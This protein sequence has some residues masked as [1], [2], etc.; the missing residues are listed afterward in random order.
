MLINKLTNGGGDTEEGFR[1]S[2][3]TRM[4]VYGV[5]ALVGFA[6]IVS[7]IIATGG[8]LISGDPTSD[9]E[10]GFG[11]G[12]GSAFVAAGLVNFLKTR[13]ALN[14]PNRFR[15]AYTEYADERNRFVIMKTYQT[16]SAIF[17]CVMALAVV[18]AATFFKNA[19]VAN[20]LG[21]CLSAFSIIVFV[22]QRIVNR[23]Y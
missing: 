20:T 18:A 15:K 12:L 11:I 4:R 21:V 1:A 2:L 9:Y 17:I 6:V 5:F 16:A 8:A 23:K 13:G 7:A 22:V 3:K 14:N 10:A 19:V